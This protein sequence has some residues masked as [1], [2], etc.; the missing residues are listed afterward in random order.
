MYSS[1]AGGVSTF[2]L[3][4]I[5]VKLFS[6]YGA[7]FATLLGVMLLTIFRYIFYKRAL[8]RDPDLLFKI[9]KAS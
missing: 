3:Q 9:N 4:I 8:K 6:I 2:I 5:L 1:L 7:A